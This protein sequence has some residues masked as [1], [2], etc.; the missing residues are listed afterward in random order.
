M[1]AVQEMYE[2]RVMV[3]PT[4]NGVLDVM[5]YD[6]GVFGGNTAIPFQCY[7]RV[8]DLFRHCLFLKGPRDGSRA[9]SNSSTAANTVLGMGDWTSQLWTKQFVSTVTGV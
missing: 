6:G 8:D 3:G 9:D 5:S 4:G 2:G 1:K 7:T